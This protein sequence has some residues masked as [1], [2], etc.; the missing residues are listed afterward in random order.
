MVKS[1]EAHMFET[2][3]EIVEEAN[4]AVERELQS[5]IAR[6]QNL[7]RLNP[8]VDQPKSKTSK[9]T[10]LPSK[11]PSPKPASVWTPSTSWLWRI[12]QK[13]LAVVSMDKKLLIF[14]DSFGL[15][16]IAENRKQSESIPVRW[17]HGWVREG[18]CV[19][20][21]LLRFLTLYLKSISSTL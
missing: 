19:Q 8:A 21:V 5:E 2:T 9:P 14:L 11:K 3:Q 6:L 7:A 13:V 1:A 4:F 10:K 18:V 15:V 17:I 20:V 16:S 12:D